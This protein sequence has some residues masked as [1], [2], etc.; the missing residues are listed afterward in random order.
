VQTATRLQDTQTFF[1]D[2][3]GIL[4]V[5]QHITGE[6]T[7]ETS[8]FER[9]IF[10]HSLTYNV[11]REISH[12]KHLATDSVSPGKLIGTRFDTIGFGAKLN[13]SEGNCQAMSGANL[14]YAF[15]PDAPVE[16][17][18][19]QLNLLAAALKI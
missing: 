8:V 1:N 13:A 7:I 19:Q 3:L 11:C 18:F 16:I 5:L 2:S 17:A 14:Q 4:D 15:A 9:D 6:N 10:S 12:L